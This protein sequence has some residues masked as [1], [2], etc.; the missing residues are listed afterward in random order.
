VKIKKEEQIPETI[1]EEEGVKKV[2]RRILIGPEDGSDNIV[3]RY[4]RVLPGGN[5][6]FH[7]H[8][9]EHV[10]RIEKG[11]GVVVNAA[12]EEILVSP[13]QSVFIPGKE[14]HQF[15]NPNDEPFEFI[16]TILNPRLNQ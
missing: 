3:M 15:K 5:T 13:G 4:F 12:Q 7:E 8:E 9:F 16:C 11:K 14:K 2:T 1:P 6:P 10:V